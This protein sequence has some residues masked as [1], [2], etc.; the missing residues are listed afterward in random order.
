MVLLAILLC[1]IGWFALLAA[2]NVTRFGVG[3]VVDCLVVV[4]L[5]D[6]VWFSCADCCVS[7]RFGCLIWCLLRLVFVDC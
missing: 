5:V 2:V 7:A 1:L 3:L 4:C 6:L